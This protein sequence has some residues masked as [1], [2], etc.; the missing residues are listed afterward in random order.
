M[1]FGML[2]IMVLTKLVRGPGGG[3]ESIFGFQI[4][5]S[6]SWIAFA[7]LIVCACVLTFIA[8][9]ISGSEHSRKVA[10]GYN[11]TRGDKELNLKGAL[12]LVFFSIFGAFFAAVCG[13]GPGTI[14]NSVLI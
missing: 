10:C 14:F 4:C 8:A 5:S 9:R 11:F 6:Q 7:V 1:N 2:A 13:I 3:Q 12:E